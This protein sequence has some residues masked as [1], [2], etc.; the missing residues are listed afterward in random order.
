M[1]SK[2]NGTTITINCVVQPNSDVSG[3][4][5][6]GAFYMQAAIMIFLHFFQIRPKD[7]FFSNLSIQVT[8]AA[9]IGAVYFDSTV[10]VTHTLV[11]SQ[12]AILFSCCRFTSYDLPT[13]VLRTK[14]T[15]KVI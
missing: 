15:I 13:S 11:A 8:S 12:F 6:R 4:G 2:W 9:L 10:D 1:F 5:I 7:I 3:I 14:V